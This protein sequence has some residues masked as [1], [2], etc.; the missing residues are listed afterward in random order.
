[1]NV[2]ISL[3]TIQIV[4]ARQSLQIA[5]GLSYLAFL[6]SQTIQAGGWLARISFNE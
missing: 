6:G 2:L 3:S 4:G 5:N 1:M